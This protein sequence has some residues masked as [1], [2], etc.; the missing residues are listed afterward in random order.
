[1]LGLNRGKRQSY[2][3]QPLSEERLISTHRN[4]NRAE[5]RGEMLVIRELLFR[6]V[7]VK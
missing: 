5:L 6:T 2:R 3:E 4:L 7:R 1:M